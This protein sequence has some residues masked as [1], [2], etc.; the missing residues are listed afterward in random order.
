MLF[1]L[2]SF[3]FN[4]TSTTE[5]YTLS[6][7]DALPIF[8]RLRHSEIDIQPWQKENCEHGHDRR[9]QEK[10]KPCRNHYMLARE[11][12]GIAGGHNDGKSREN[13]KGGD[14]ADRPRPAHESRQQSSGD[15]RRGGKK[16]NKL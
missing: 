15:C 2:T 5:I 9:N 7:H 10:T 14:T 4:P 3:F 1:L 6:L 13:D 12:N 11:S 8:G 16:I